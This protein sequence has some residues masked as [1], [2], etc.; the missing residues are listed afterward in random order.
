[1]N[2]IFACELGSY[3]ADDTCM[4]CPEVCS[5]CT[6]PDMCTSCAF[7]DLNVDPVDGVC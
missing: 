4:T 6:S 2:A 7:E 1:M 3:P 5:E